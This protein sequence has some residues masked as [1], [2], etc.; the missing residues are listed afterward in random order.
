[1]FKLFQKNGKTKIVDQVFTHQKFKWNYC[2]KILE[3]DSQTVFIGWFEDSISQLEQALNATN[4]SSAKVLL[5]RTTSR[6]QAE[7]SQIIFL[8]H[9]PMKSKEDIF[10][11][12]LGLKE[13]IVLIALDEPLLSLFGCEK[14]IGIMQ[15]LGMNEDEMIEHKLVSESI[16]NAQ[17]KIEQRMTIEQSARSSSEWIERNLK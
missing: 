9:H 14:L 6:S 1:M 17:R 5:A 11:S 2:L 7:G 12:Q 3:K 4:N 16:A 15:K 10:Y 8:E 13:A